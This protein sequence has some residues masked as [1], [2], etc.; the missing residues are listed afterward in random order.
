MGIISSPKSSIGNVFDARGDNQYFIPQYQ[1]EYSWSRKDWD[2]L[3]DD[4]IES[5]EHFIGSIITMAHEENNDKGSTTK[6]FDVIDGQQ[7][8]VTISLLFCAIY[9]KIDSKSITIDNERLM[10][11]Y[12][13]LKKAVVLSKEPFV[14]RMVL[15]TQGKN[16]LIFDNIQHGTSLPLP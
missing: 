8:L 7:R 11:L 9:S 4:V 5:N 15:Q 16:I 13:Q 10:Q 14:P 1:R 12:L 3:F 6:K 2:A